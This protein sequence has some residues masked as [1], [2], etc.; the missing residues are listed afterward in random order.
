MPKLPNVSNSPSPLGLKLVIAGATFLLLLVSMGVLYFF[1]RNALKEQALLDVEQTLEGTIQ[2]VDNILL[3]VEQSA[4]NFYCDLQGHLDKP[5]EMHIYCRELLK[6]NP[7]IIGCAIAFKPDYYP[8]RKL[9]MTY[10]HR[11]NYST[12]KKAKLVT[13]DTFTGKPYTE[14]SWYTEPMATG[15]PLWTNPLKGDET[16]DEPIVSFCIPISDQ[17][18]ALVGVMTVDVSINQFSRIV[19]ASKPSENS[20]SILM[21]SNGSYIVHPDPKM[22]SLKSVHHSLSGVATQETAEALLSKETGIRTFHEDGRD[23]CLF[24][25]PFHRT[26]VSGRSPDNPGWSAGVIYPEED[27]FGSY[28]LLIYLVLIIAA[29]GLLIFFVLS[30]LILRWQL[31]PLHQ[32]SLTAGHIAEGNYKELIPK[33]NRDDELGQLQ[34]HFREM[35]KSLTA[36]V[37]EIEHVTNTVMKHNEV[38]LR[39]Y[40][41]ALEADKTKI[42]FIHYIS[43]KMSQPT[44]TIDRTVTSLCNNYHN[45]T[46]QE[47]KQQVD[48]INQ[49]SKS[50]VDLLNHMNK[51]SDSGTGK[52][53]SV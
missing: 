33:S 52:E 17:N 4:G 12:D 11:K 8:G 37:G 23:W 5:E 19:L 51:F 6:I 34:K 1:S 24:F 13:T 32:L 22:L 36:R 14:Q 16:E 27:I 35:Q 45:I 9:F 46:P 38:L 2:D 7:N 41:K 21:A 25:K 15:R 26:G 18:Q 53:G 44:D 31:K 39:A 10:V 30:S 42:S 49:Q 48:M 20:Y 43:N 29:G 3:N 40:T 50:I 47:I 28:N